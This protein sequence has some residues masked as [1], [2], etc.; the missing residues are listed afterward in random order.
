MRFFIKL[1]FVSLFCT[2]FSFAQQTNPVDRQIAN[3]LTD[4][5]NINPVA[6]QT[7]VSNKKKKDA[8]IIEGGDDEVVVYS[9]NQDV[10]GKEGERILTHTGNVDARYGI[11]RM[12]ANK[13]TIIQAK[14]LFIA[15]GNVIFDQGNDQRITG[16]RAEW[17]Y[18]T[19]L[20]YFVDST[21]FTNQT[22]DGTI[23]YFSADRVERT[24]LDSIKIIN[25][26]FTACED[27]T[28]PWSFTS[29]E[30]I[31]ISKKSLKLKNP[32]FR[33]LDVPIAQLPFISIPLRTDDR[34]SGFLTPTFGF[35]ANKGFRLST[36]YYQT[37]GRSADVTFRGDY[38]SSRGVGYGADFRVRTNSRSYLNAGFYA[39]QDRIFGKKESA[40]NPDQ[41]GTTVYAEGVQFFNNGFTAA[42]D[43]RLTSSLPFRQVF[44]DGIQQVISP[45]EVSKGFVNKS[46]NDYTL[47]VLAKSEVISIP[48]LRVKTRNLPS[49]NF[50]KRLSPLPFT[51]NLYFGFKTSLDGVSRR[52]AVDD[53]KLYRDIVGS[54]PIVTPALGQRFD[55]FPEISIPITTK[56]ATITATAGFRSTYYSNSLDGL[57]RVMGTDIIRSYGEI[58]LDVRPVALA[59]NFY[60]ENDSFRFRHVIEPYFTYRFRK[61]VNDF[62]RIIRFDYA[63]TVS[64]TNE[65]E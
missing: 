2:L 41:G 7:T 3:P 17:N 24:G 1:I 55:I 31:V 39:V 58:E 63:D 37:L 30:A 25:G 11:Y 26:K 33:V 43:V 60:R 56:Y 38:F 10:E 14:N 62:N 22:S 16:T 51:K 59:K 29:K 34:K 40:E 61:G 8:L 47:N 19:K 42:V 18:K 48:N 46:W 32:K 21:G 4:T 45:I 23:I 44:S 13:I 64:D 50:E 27:A 15:E 6:D 53:L 65:L 54:D 28:A 52:E 20:G 36:A 9:K 5:P 12:Q 57:R 49:I 35:S